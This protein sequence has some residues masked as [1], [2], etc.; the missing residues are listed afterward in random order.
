MI[1]EICSSF[2][3]FMIGHILRDLKVEI[4]VR[5]VTVLSCDHFYLTELLAVFSDIDIAG[6][7]GDAIAP[8]LGI[9]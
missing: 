4:S 5:A 7:M 6:E 1:V 9:E 8:V 2:F 3:V